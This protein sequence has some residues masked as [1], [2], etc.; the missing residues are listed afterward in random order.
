MPKGPRNLSQ[1]RHPGLPLSDDVSM[2]DMDSF[3]NLFF[4]RLAL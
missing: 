1:L 3:F 4:P 2:L